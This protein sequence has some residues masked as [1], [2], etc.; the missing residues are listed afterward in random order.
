M[1]DLVASKGM[2]EKTHGVVGPSGKEERKEAF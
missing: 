1:E 2:P